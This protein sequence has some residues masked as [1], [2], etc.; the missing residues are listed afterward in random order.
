MK[1]FILGLRR[2]GTTIFWRSFRQDKRLL[3]F[4]EPFNPI[5]SKLPK[6]DPYNGYSEYIEL[7]SS[8]PNLFWSRYTPISPAEELDR[9]FTAAQTKYLK[10][11]V[12]KSSHQCFD[13]TRC[14]FKIEKLYEIAPEAI[15]IHLYRSP[16]CFT[17]SHLLPS[18]RSDGLAGE[19]R[20]K[21]REASFFTRRSRFDSWSVETSI[22]T[23]KDT[24]L[25]ELR[26]FGLSEV[27][28]ERL[29]AYQKLMLYW[30]V[31][32]EHIERIGR[33][34]FG[35]K[36]LSVSFEQ[37]CSDPQATLD[38]VYRQSELARFV[39]DVDEIQVAKSAFKKNDKRWLWKNIS[40]V[41]KTETL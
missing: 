2:S 8:E 7:I 26:S 24:F 25:R 22:E 3:C 36:F 34:L 21:I 14:H 19:F 9:E 20:Q 28:F 6:V 15:V 13:F 32:Y 16:Q 37:F 1:V 10:Y 40:A 31:N 5:I 18:I 17:T 35:S 29:R 4:N 30:R 12:G 11:L 38:S 41:K 23:Q 33:M 39:M 27:E